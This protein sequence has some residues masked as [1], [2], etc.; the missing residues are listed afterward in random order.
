MRTAVD[1][2][3]SSSK[4]ERT[5]QSGRST[6][7]SRQAGD[8]RA[9]GPLVALLGRF[10]FLYFFNWGCPGWGVDI[11]KQADVSSTRQGRVE[12]RQ[13]EFRRAE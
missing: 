1:G 3:C 5:E 2:W 11:Q 6:V 10:R 7:N 4:S 12:E 13:L 8:E 9:L